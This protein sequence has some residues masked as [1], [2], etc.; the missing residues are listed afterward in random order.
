MGLDVF[1]SS[2]SI[3]D[4]TIFSNFDSGSFI[5][6]WICD[7]RVYD[8]NDYYSV[9]FSI[10]DYGSITYSLVDSLRYD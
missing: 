4:S 9:T 7:W 6:L 8:F 1:G 3:S 10:K 2:I 5:S